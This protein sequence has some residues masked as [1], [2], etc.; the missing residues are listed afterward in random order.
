[1]PFVRFAEVFGH[2]HLHR[3]SQQFLASVAEQ[4][5]SHAVEQYDPACVVEL[6]DCVGS[7]L[8]EFP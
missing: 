7:T 3:L 6:K 8:Q 1:M 5:L 2:Q 4:M